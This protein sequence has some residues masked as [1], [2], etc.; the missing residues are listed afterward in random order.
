MVQK[1]PRYIVGCTPRVNG[2]SPGKPSASTPC[3]PGTSTG[4]RSR[5]LEVSK[6]LRRSAPFATAFD[7]TFVRQRSFSAFQSLIAPLGL[8]LS[9]SRV[10]QKRGISGG[11]PRHDMSDNTLAVVL[12]NVSGSRFGEAAALLSD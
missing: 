6:R 2:Y 9:A 12:E 5:P 1:R 3:P 11:F 10:S 8:H 7:Q 4:A